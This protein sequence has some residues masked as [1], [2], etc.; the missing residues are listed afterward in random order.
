MRLQVVK[1][2]RILFQEIKPHQ[3]LFLKIDKKLPFQMIFILKEQQEITNNAA[4][5]SCL[6]RV[7][8]VS[9]SVADQ[10]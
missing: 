6:S 8:A 1:Q 10:R 7:G 2:N 5:I 9:P 4:G 3:L